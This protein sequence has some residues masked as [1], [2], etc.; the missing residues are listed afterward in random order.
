MRICVIGTGYVGLVS[1]ACLAD[2]GHD[3]RCV[4]VNPERV[5]E[6]N[7]GKS[8]IFEEGLDAILARN[9]GTR[10]TATT[11]LAAAFAD[12]TDLSI[13]AVGTPYDGEEIDLFWI[14]K[15]AR[16]IGAALRDKDGYHVVVVKSTVVPGRRTRS[17]SR[18]WRSGREGEPGRTSAWG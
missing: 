11:D 12:A 18:R 6:V 7:Q 17:F 4:D 9:V 3:V 1:G 16:Q 13:I 14:R 8:P 2:L 15:A 5:D 10:L